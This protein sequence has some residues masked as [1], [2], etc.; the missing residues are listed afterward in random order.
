MKKKITIVTVVPDRTGAD[1]PALID[2][3]TAAATDFVLGLIT[4]AEFKSS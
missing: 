4:E 3:I 1:L 2:L